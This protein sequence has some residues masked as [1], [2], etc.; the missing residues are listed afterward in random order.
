MED[1]CLMAVYIGDGRSK[2]NNNDCLIGFGNCTLLSPIMLPPGTV[3]ALSGMPP[4]D[5]AMAM[6]HPTNRRALILRLSRQALEALEKQSQPNVEID[7]GSQPV[8]KY[9][10]LLGAAELCTGNL[11]QQRLLPGR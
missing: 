9:T 11:H 2:K 4:K 3:C 7:L 5:A 6:S 8:R 10:P 1:A